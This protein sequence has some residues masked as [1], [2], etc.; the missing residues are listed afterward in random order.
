MAL[1]N[2]GYIYYAY[3]ENYDIT[4][5]KINSNGVLQWSVPAVTNSADDIIKSIYP[6]PSSGCVIIYESQSFIEGSHIYAVAVDGTGQIQN[7]WPV[8]LSDLSGDQY[9]ESSVQTEYG[10]FVSFK[11]NSSGNYDIFGQYLIFNGN[12][13]FSYFLFLNKKT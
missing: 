10:I 7:E 1:G 12:L 3:S 8:I 13:I 4:V 9:F 2:D 6:Y 5:K 11:G